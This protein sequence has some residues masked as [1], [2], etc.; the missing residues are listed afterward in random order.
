MM[1]FCHV[2][3]ERRIGMGNWAVSYL[4]SF[5]FPSLFEYF[6]FKIS[7]EMIR[8]LLQLQL[9]ACKECIFSISIRHT[10]YWILI[11]KQRDM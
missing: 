1:C 3:I 8:E 9:Q 6:F 7:S 2:W 5:F 4:M 11:G 10:G